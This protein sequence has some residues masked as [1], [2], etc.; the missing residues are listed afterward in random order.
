[1]VSQTAK[2]MKNKAEKIMIYDSHCPLCQWY[3]GEF[4][5][6]GMLN[7]NGRLAFENATRETFQKLDLVKS[8]HEIPLMDAN[9]GE[10]IYGLDSLKYMLGLK[11]PK[12]ISILNFQPMYKLTKEFYSLDFLQPKSH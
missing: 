10:T 9:G 6:Q 8:R 1:M 11:F 2:A 5:K 4:V 3:T 12:L 7:E